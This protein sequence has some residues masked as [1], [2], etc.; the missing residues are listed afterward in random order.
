MCTYGYT[1]IA[2]ISSGILLLALEETTWLHRLFKNRYLTNLGIIS[3]GFYIFHDMP[4]SMLVGANKFFFAKR[5][6]SFLLALVSFFLTYA[7]AWLS[8][9]YFESPFLE[10]KK[11]LAPGHRS[12]PAGNEG[13]DLVAK[14]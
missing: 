10:L 1:L 9:R 2:L 5:H 14:Y 3:Y 4:T 8:F 13:K 7:A 11:R 12:V 6:L